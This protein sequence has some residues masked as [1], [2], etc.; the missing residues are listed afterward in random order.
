MTTAKP[1]C[2][3]KVRDRDSYQPYYHN[4]PFTGIKMEDGEWWCGHHIPSV[5]K[6]HQE[7]VSLASKARWD[8]RWYICRKP[9]HAAF[10]ALLAAAEHILGIIERD[11][12]HGIPGQ[13]Q[14]QEA[15]AQAKGTEGKNHVI[16]D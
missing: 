5:V 7:A 2:S 16:H 8:A 9:E 12:V 6:A 10:D 15:V 4:C 11:Y 1:M 3:E 13:F 14:L